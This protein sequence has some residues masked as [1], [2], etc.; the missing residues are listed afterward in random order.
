MMGTQE[1]CSNIGDLFT[2]TRNLQRIKITFGTQG[3][4][5]EENPNIGITMELIP[6]PC[7]KTSVFSINN[8]VCD[9]KTFVWSWLSKSSPLLVNP[10]LVL[11]HQFHVISCLKAIINHTTIN[12]VNLIT[13]F[14]AY[15]EIVITRSL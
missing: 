12:I 3:D 8:E 2:W 1:S 13:F 5:G 4:G 15:Q 6:I 14:T 10:N 11:T 9:L 7:F